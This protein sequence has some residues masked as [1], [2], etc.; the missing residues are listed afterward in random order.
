MVVDGQYLSKCA[1]YLNSYHRNLLNLCNKAH[2]K[3]SLFLNKKD[4]QNG[5]Q[6]MSGFFHLFQ[7]YKP[8]TQCAEEQQ[9]AVD[10]SGDGQRNQALKGFTGKGKAQNDEKLR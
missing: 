2:Q 5:S 9:Q 1:L 6:K 3:L 4:G 8:Q 10:G 7:L